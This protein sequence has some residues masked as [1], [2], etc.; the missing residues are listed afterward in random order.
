M[1]LFVLRTVTIII[2]IR[3]NNDFDW[4]ATNQYSARVGEGGCFTIFQITWP[5]K[6]N[7]LYTIIKRICSMIY[8][9]V[10]FLTFIN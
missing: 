2:V 3:Y 5:R 10:K 8:S 9:Y 1:K 7:K 6:F 4:A